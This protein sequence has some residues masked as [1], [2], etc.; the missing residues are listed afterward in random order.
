MINNLSSPQ[1]SRRMSFVFKDKSKLSDDPKGKSDL[2]KDQS[3]YSYHVNNN[4]QPVDNDKNTYMPYDVHNGNSDEVMVMNSWGDLIGKS[5]VYSSDDVNRKLP[6]QSNPI[7]DNYFSHRNSIQTSHILHYPSKESPTTSSRSKSDIYPFPS[8]MFDDDSDNSSQN[9]YIYGKRDLYK[10]EL[11]RSWMESGTCRYANKCQFAHGPE[12]LR[13]VTRH[14]KYKTEICK[15][16]HTS[17]TCPYGKRCRFVHFSTNES[18]PKEIKEK[19]SH[20]NVLPKSPS[21][22]TSRLPVF[23][24]LI[25]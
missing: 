5:N 18:N 1:T 7:E 13:P 15:T 11:C 17:G 22:K 16:F 20:I 9:N 8:N 24:K 6:I 19:L 14:P 3:P 4:I 23:K 25:Q 12:E 21:G 10:T 2:C